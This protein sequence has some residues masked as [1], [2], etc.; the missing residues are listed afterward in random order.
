MFAGL[1]LK[2]DNEHILLHQWNKEMSIAINKCTKAVND[3]KSAVST[4]TDG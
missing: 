1:S 4:W 2:V 3:D